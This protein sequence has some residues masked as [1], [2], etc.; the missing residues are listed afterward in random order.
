RKLRQVRILCE[1]TGDAMGAEPRAQAV[2]ERIEIGRKFFG[3]Q[4]DLH[5]RQE[6]GEENA[7]AGEIEA[8]AGIERISEPMEPLAK[9]CANA[10]G[11]AYRPRGCDRDAAHGAV[12]AEQNELDLSRP[13]AAALEHRFEAG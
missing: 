7:E 4:I 5:F 13:L 3:A 8:E 12:G 1:E 11:I 6:L 9:Q 10:G 2:D